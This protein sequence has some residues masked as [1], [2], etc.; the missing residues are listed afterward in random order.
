MCGLKRE[1]S[2]IFTVMEESG[3][4]EV[5]EGKEVAEAV[6]DLVKDAV[7]ARHLARL[8]SLSPA[9]FV[10]PDKPQAKLSFTTDH[11]P[12]QNNFLPIRYLFSL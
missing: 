2:R 11:I 1:A 4:G 10:L 5:G 8:Q 3:E 12:P 9:S 6:P 7:K